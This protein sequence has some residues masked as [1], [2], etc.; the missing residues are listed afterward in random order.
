MVLI[1]FVPLLAMAQPTPAPA[2]RPATAEP[3][4][5][6]GEVNYENTSLDQVIK[7][8]NEVGP[9]FQA[10]LAGGVQTHYPLVT[11]HLRDVTPE[12]V[13]KV[14]EKQQM[15]LQVDSAGDPPIYVVS[16][17]SLD[18]NPPPPMFRVTAYCLTPIIDQLMSS[19]GEHAVQTNVPTTQESD[20][21]SRKA[22][23]NDVVNVVQT[24]VK[25]ASNETTATM[26][27]VHEPTEMLIL[28]G[29][30][31]QREAAECVLRALEPRPG[32]VVRGEGRPPHV[33]G[34]GGQGR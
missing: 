20:G 9:S 6:M 17:P 27:E 29:T 30:A 32:M 24:A 2:T 7:S 15:G 33:T 8:L 28:K 10:V 3:A 18:A 34:G 12:Q 22:A 5:I 26:I 4:R 25:I 14:M 16:F 13:L 19:R 21:K 23:I 31:E 11:L 1:G